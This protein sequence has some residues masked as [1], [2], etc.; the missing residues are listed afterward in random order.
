MADESFQGA[1]LMPQED[2]KNLLIKDLYIYPIKSCAGIQV[3]QARLDEY[4]FVYDRRWLIGRQDGHFLSQREFPQMALISPIPGTEG[5]ILRAPGMQDLLV[6]YTLNSTQHVQVWQDQMA[7]NQQGQ[8]AAEWISDFLHTPACLYFAGSEHK[9]RVESGR[10]DFERQTA[11]SDSYP[12]LLTSM[13]SLD[14]LNTRINMAKGQAIPMDRFRPNIIIDGARPFE[15]DQWHTL[16][17]EGTEFLHG[18]PCSR[19]MITTIDQATGIVSGPEPLRTLSTFRRD[20]RG[21]VLFGIYLAHKSTGAVLRKGSS[22]YI[23]SIL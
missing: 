17:I 11:Y 15:E 10:I 20:A 2:S 12:L 7:G 18:K 13:S 16:L 1:A 6:E 19:C 4:G 21:K 8:P 22:V 5:L 23:N 3:E 14:E 9:R